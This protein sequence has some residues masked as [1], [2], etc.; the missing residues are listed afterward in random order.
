MVENAWGENIYQFLYHLDPDTRKKKKTKKKLQLK[1]IK[2]SIVFY[3]T[4]LNIRVCVCER[5]SIYIYIYIYIYK[6]M[7]VIEDDQKAPFSIATT[8]RCRGGRYSFPWIVPLYIW[9]IPYI[10]EWEVRRYQ[11][12]FLK[13][14][15]WC[16]LGLN[17]CLLDHWWTLY[18]LGQWASYIY[19]FN[20]AKI[21]HYSKI[22]IRAIYLTM[23]KISS[24]IITQNCNCLP[25]IMIMVYL[26][27]PFIRANKSLLNRDIW[28]Q[29]ILY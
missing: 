10:A 29:I 4:C 28:N 15:V 21:G 26:V 14:L 5:E 3:K 2:C 27:K 12:P 25:K 22:F 13:S 20:S 17:H 7:T 9:Y 16:D 18:P 8:P 11:V 1:I 19:N 23:Q 24:R 6:L